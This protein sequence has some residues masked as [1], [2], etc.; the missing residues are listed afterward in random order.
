MFE[1]LNVVS[2]QRFWQRVFIWSAK[3]RHV[4][5]DNNYHP[6]AIIDGVELRKI[7]IKLNPSMKLVHRQQLISKY[8]PI[9]GNETD[10]KVN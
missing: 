9:I 6:F 3:Q 4:G 8:L 7:I 10:S 2:S 1:T 5:V